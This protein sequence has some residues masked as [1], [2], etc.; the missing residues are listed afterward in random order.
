MVNCGRRPPV[1]NETENWTW[2]SLSLLLRSPWPPRRC[3]FAVTFGITSTDNQTVHI[4]S[5]HDTSIDARERSISVCSP[6]LSICPSDWSEVDAEWWYYVNWYVT[7]RQFISSSSCLDKPVRRQ[8]Q[9]LRRRAAAHLTGY[10][11]AG[12]GGIFADAVL[13]DWCFSDAGD[14]VTSRHTWTNSSPCTNTDVNDKHK[15]KNSSAY[16]V[17]QTCT[18][19][20]ILYVHYTSVYN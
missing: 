6:S 17:K 20:Q 11:S 14:P 16:V 3:W 1:T 12:D 8:L 19:Q 10:V 4:I 13:T 2:T 9:K 5:Q 15:Y 18:N 7:C